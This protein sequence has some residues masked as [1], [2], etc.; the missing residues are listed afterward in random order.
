V[1]GE[2]ELA[3]EIGSGDV[4]ALEFRRF[5]TACGK[6]RSSQRGRGERG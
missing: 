1:P 5:R 3:A 6:Q 2:R 4:G